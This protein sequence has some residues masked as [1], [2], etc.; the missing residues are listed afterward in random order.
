MNRLGR[1]KVRFSGTSMAS[2]NTVNLAAKLL[3]LDPALTPAQVT[4]LIVAGATAS[5]DGRRHNID[6]RRS[7]ELLHQQAHSSGQ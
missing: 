6:E 5:D 4:H 1:Y 2:P 3:A 7:V